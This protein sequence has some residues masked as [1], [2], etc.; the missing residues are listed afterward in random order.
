MGMIVLP[1]IISTLISFIATPIMRI[2]ALKVGAVDIPKDDRRVH[3]KG[4]P[5]LGGVA[6]YLGV[7]IS[8]L[9][10]I[11][12][13]STTTISILIGGTLIMLSGL[14]DDFKDISPKAKLLIQII[15]GIILVAGGVKINFITNP[16][17][18][19]RGLIS[20][21]LF[22]IPI[23]IFWVVG[24][25]NTVN[26]IDGLDGLSAGVAAISSL[27]IML[28]AKKFGYNDTAIF[29]AILAGGCIGFLPFNFNPASIFMGDA[30]A[31]FL[32]FMLAAISIVGVMKSAATIAVVVPIIILGIPIFDT[33]FAIF[34][35]LLNGQHPMQADKGHLHHRLL[36]R[37]YS[38]RKTVL[39]L[40]AISAFFGIFAVL[41]SEVNSKRTVII[42]IAMLFIGT[43]YLASKIGLFNIKDR[44]NKDNSKEKDG[45]DINGED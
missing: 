42:S 32:G 24:I 22:S 39:I 37:G 11:P 30:G 43:I 29:A 6:I 38:Q 25:T 1:F 4:I 35:R 18:A 20:L 21:G 28:V 13:K 5:Y 3:K 23:T 41:I 2:I 19:S 31:L 10:Y 15:A 33:T 27:S 14:V 34:R 7:I 12:L 26:L 9:I 17:S 45:K 16:F 36:K 44:K 8:I 40:Y